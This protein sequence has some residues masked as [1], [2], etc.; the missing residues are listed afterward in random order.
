MEGKKTNTSVSRS[1]VAFFAVLINVEPLSLDLRRDAQTDC[2]SYDRADDRASDHRE[3]DCDDDGFQLFD[4]QRVTDNSGKTVLGRRIERSGNGYRKIWIH[5]RSRQQS[6]Q[7]CAERPAYCV[8]PERIERIV[9]AEPR[10][11]FRAGKKRDNSRSDPDNHCT[12]RTDVS[13][14]RR[15]YDQ[16]GDRTGAKPEHTRFAAQRVLEHRPGK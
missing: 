8:D 1:Y 5:S 4:P 13:T 12:T 14:G 16:S 3:H 2:S 6:R 9:I 10:F 15:D 11:Q 7:K